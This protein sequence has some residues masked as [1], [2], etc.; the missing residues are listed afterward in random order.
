[1]KYYISNSTHQLVRGESE[2]LLGLGWRDDIVNHHDPRIVVVD[3]NPLRSQS[4]LGGVWLVVTSRCWIAPSLS[5]GAEGLSAEQ[6]VPLHDLLS[7]RVLR[8]L[9]LPSKADSKVSTRHD[10]VYL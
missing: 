9:S 1:M 7:H 5:E 3:L 2:E 10:K 8:Q 6:S 4:G